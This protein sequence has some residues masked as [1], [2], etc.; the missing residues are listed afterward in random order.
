M[1]PVTTTVSSPS[2]LDTYRFRIIEQ[3]DL[4]PLLAAVGLTDIVYQTEGALEEMTLASRMTVRLRPDSL[5]VAHSSLQIEH[6]FAGTNPGADLFRAAKTE[7]TLLFDNPFRPAPIA[8]LE[9]DLSF[10]PGRDLVYL[11]SARA[12]V[13]RARPGQKVGIK[14]GLRDYRGADSEQVLSI[15]LP[16]YVPDGR[17]K[18]IIAPPDSLLAFEAM[19]APAKLEP[20]SFAEL[21][22]L[23]RQTGRENE[24]AVAGFSDKPGVL[25]GDV[26][27]PAPPP[28]LRA[29]LVNP[30][31]AEPVTTTSESPVFRQTFRFDRIISGVAR[32]ELEVRREP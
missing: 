26:E 19:R 18:L 8:G 27:L 1:L 2:G 4:A 12:D 5:L 31:S 9:F 32:L 28:S 6:R 30:R 14:L 10:T 15:T 3:E 23:C 29:A 21:L 13:A 17:L 11:L 20:G 7:L 22:E 16:E 25:H 24:L